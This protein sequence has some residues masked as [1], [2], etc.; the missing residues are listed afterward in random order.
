MAPQCHLDYPDWPML[1]PLLSLVVVVPGSTILFVL[2]Y[3]KA[4]RWREQRMS[5]T[6]RMPPC[7]QEKG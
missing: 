6:R 1:Y 2:A 7:W 4:G 3:E 5:S